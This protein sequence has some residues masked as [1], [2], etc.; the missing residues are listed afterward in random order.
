MLPSFIKLNQNNDSFILLK[1]KTLE[2]FFYIS[3]CR[4]VYNPSATKNKQKA[5]IFYDL[6]ILVL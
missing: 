5:F 2:A 1:I 4:A 6:N 3:N